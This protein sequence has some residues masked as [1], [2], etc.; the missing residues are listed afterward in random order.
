MPLR[1]DTPFDGEIS[2]SA[3][4]E[5]IVR[6]R[7]RERSCFFAMKAALYDAR[8]RGMSLADVITA[9]ETL[10]P[11]TRLE[12]HNAIVAFDLSRGDDE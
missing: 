12:M 10:T 11:A 5:L 9:M 4:R 1:Q 2:S 7:A 8:E 6:A 3:N